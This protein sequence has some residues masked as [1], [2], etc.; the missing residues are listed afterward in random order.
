MTGGRKMAAWRW[1][2]S[3]AAL[4]AVCVPFGLAQGQRPQNSHPAP[5]QQYRPPRSVRPPQ[6]RPNAQRGQRPYP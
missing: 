1:A 3:A 2:A 6:G 5:R 4:A